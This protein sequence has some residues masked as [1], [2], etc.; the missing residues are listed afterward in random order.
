MP[1]NKKRRGPYVAHAA[2]ISHR[3]GS[4]LGCR[5]EILLNLF[6]SAPWVPPQGVIHTAKNTRMSGVP[7][8]NDDAT[9]F[10]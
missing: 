9:F 2:G 7:F 3:R 1:D 8:V 10:N 5:R 4:W 6:H